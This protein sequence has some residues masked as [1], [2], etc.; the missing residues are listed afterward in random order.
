MKGLDILSYRPSPKGAKLGYLELVYGHLTI[1]G[2]TLMRSGDRLW[3]GLPAVERRDREGQPL[4][5][6]NGKRQFTPTV[7]WTSRAGGDKVQAALLDI[8][9]RKFPDA[10]G[11]GQ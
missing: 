7:G 11:G 3:I 5:D 4:L 9:H 8:L 6:A 2:A 10:I 1:Y